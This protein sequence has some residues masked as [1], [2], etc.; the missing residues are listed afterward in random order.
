MDSSNAGTTVGEN[1]SNN[2]NDDIKFDAFGN[3]S[4]SADTAAVTGEDVSFDAF[5]VG[6]ANKET[7]DQEMSFATFGSSTNGGA[8]DDDDEV[9]FE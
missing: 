1:S 9:K 6:N 7:A 4:D 2:G 3:N 5:G 8:G